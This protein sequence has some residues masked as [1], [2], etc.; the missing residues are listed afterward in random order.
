MNITA[1]YQPEFESLKELL[2]EMAQERSVDVQL[3]LAA[4]R[5]AQRP[6]VALAGIWLKRPGDNCRNCIKKKVCPDRSRCLHLIAGAGGEDINEVNDFILSDPFNHRIPIGF[7]AIGNVAAKGK[8]SGINGIESDLLWLSENSWAK[9]LGFISF[10][11]QP[12]LHKEEGLGVI[13]VYSRIRLERIGE[14]HFWLRMIAN[15]SSLAIA[16]ARALEQIQA[17][18][19]QLELENAYLRKEIDDVKS[20]GEIIG[21]SPPLL[22]VLNQ[23]ELVAPTDATVVIYGE[24]GTGKELIAREIHQRSHRQTKPM[25]TVNCST[26]P[27]NL[28]ESEFF[29]HVKGAFTGAI[30][31]RIGRFQAADGGTL[32]LDEVGEIPYKLQSKLLR[33]LQEGSYERIGEDNTRR[34]DVRII[35][36]TNKDLKREVKENRFR[37]DLFYRL[38]VFPIEI[39]PLRHRNQDIPLLANHFLKIICDRLN[40]PRLSLSRKN[41]DELQQFNWPGN[42]RELQNVIERAVITSTSGKLRFDLPD[43]LPAREP[44][45]GINAAMEQIEPGKVLTDAQMQEQFR[46]NMMM[47]LDSCGW[48]IYGPDG[49]A[50]LLG[51]KPTTLASRMKRMNLKPTVKF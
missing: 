18:K 27:E 46:A 47:A 24:S 30:N 4:R 48:K 25:L 36:A 33:V 32:F 11:A 26:I 35:A 39:A 10:G 20:F 45:E 38:N 44:T 3:R 5:L 31:E 12:L 21:N 23:V 9:G 19:T 1:D 42:I 49:A 43:D 37:E 29:G 17:L 34:V 2:V 15:L 50:A 7:G 14:G 8:P 22:N 6:H 13:A 41:A 40:C 51:L 28:Y 16:N